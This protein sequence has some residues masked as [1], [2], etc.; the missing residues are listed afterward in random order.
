MR[1]YCRGRYGEVLSEVV[2]VRW[3]GVKAN[4]DFIFIETW[5]GYR[6]ASRDPRSVQYLFDVD[7]SNEALGAALVEVLA[8]SRFVLPAPRTDV[9]I[10][11][12]VTFG[13]DLYDYKN[14]IERY[15]EWT[16]ALMENYGYK[17]K[18][19]LFKDMKSCE[20]EEREGMIIIGPSHHEKLEAW[21]REKGDGIEDVVIATSSSH[22]GIG[23]ALRLAFSRCTG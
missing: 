6:S 19:A 1:N 3:G 9:L 4:G 21:G 10:H 11:P 13:A 7:A 16:K 20:I 5:S 14:D 23:A 22:A 8:H 17:T 12:E 15:A 18:R 2:G